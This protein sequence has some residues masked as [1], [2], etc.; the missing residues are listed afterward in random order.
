MLNVIE[1]SYWVPR[2]CNDKELNVAQNK[3]DCIEYTFNTRSKMFAHIIFSPGI[4]KGFEDEK[5]VIKRLRPVFE[6]AGKPGI[7]SVTEPEGKLGIFSSPRAC[8]EGQRSEYF[9][10]PMPR[11]KLGIFPSPGAYMEET[12]E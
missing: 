7:F 1:N 9:Q 4:I 8:I 10:V 6:G 12:K 5:I 3:S 2:E 11:R